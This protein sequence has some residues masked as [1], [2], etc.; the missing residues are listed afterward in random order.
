MQVSIDPVP[1]AQGYYIRFG[2][3]PDELYTH[4]QVM[5]DRLGDEPV[6]IGCLNRGTAYYVTVDAYNEAGV[7]PGQ[8]V[9]T[10]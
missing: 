10:C 5:G 8:V 2:I 1:D 6:H 7:T 3:A 4:Y 9:L